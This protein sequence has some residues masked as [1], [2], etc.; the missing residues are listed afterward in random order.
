MNKG[1]TNSTLKMCTPLSVVLV[2]S[3]SRNPHVRLNKA[4]L[5]QP[6]CSFCCQC[7]ADIDSHKMRQDMLFFPQNFPALSCAFLSTS[8]T[9]S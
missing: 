8:H 6:L 3:S 4:C 2:I 1:D 7:Y 9:V 5:R